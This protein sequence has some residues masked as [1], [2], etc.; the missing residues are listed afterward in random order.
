MMG[1]TK[2]P[3]RYFQAGGITIQLN[4][5]IPGSWEH[6]LADKFIHFE[7]EKPGP[8]TVRICHHLGEP[9]RE[10][11]PGDFKTVLDNETWKIA[12]SE[13]VC[14]YEYLSE[15]FAAVPY[16]VTNI[17]TPD[18]SQG[19]VYFKDITVQDYSRLKLTSLT[20]L[21]TDQILIAKLLAGRD[22][23]LFHSNGVFLNGKTLLFTG[24]TGIGKSTISGMMEN[25]GGKIFCDDRIMIQKNGPGFISS[26]SWIPHIAPPEAVFTK[27]ID[28]VFFIEQSLHNNI[29]PITKTTLKYE[30]AMKSLVKN[31]LMPDQWISTLGLLETFVKTIPF[32]SLKFNLTNEICNLITK[33]IKQR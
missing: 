10:I 20:G 15:N 3:T 29:I 25:I 28:A 2:K 6:T 31:F 7:V 13:N 27:K 1:Q 14:I 24:K 18:H 5:E 23:F 19:N 32:Y 30:K 16:A 17:F 21:G 11:H 8:D 22:G 9:P 4:S 33:E 12:I 26:G